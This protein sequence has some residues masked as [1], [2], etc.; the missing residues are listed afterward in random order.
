MNDALLSTSV[1]RRTVLLSALGATAT[2][3]LGACTSSSAARKPGG[4]TNPR[5]DA[6]KK[7]IDQTEASRAANGTVISTD[8][9]MK[10]ATVDLGGLTA[11]TWTFGGELPG[12]LIRAKV[13]DTLKIAVNNSLPQPTTVH[14]HG[15]ALRN[16]MDGVPGLTQDPIGPGKAFEYTFLAAHPGTY[17]FHPHVGVQQ[18]RGLYAPLII[19]DPN[20]AGAYDAE[21]IVVLDDWTDGVG[22]SP[23]A[24]LADL[25]KNGMNMDRMDHSGMPM[26]YSEANPLGADTGDV[27]Y[28]HY[29]INGKLPTAPSTFT[30]SPGQRIRIRIINA[31]A[32]TAFRVAL[33][34]HRM[35]V[36]HTD[37]FPIIPTDVDALLLGMGERYDV[38]VTTGD[39]AFALTAAPVGKQ[40]APA[41]AVMKTGAGTAAPAGEMP[42]TSGVL[43]TV[44]K[45]QAHESVELKKTKMSKKLPATLGGDMMTY[46]WTINGVAHVRDKGIMSITQGDTGR[47]RIKNATMMFHPMHLHGHTFQVRSVNGVPMQHGPRKDTV[48]VRPME[49]VDVDFV[50][51]NPGSWM[52]HCHNAYHGEAGMMTAI[53][54]ELT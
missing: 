51:D 42:T 38:I 27:D 13:G 5:A 29:L 40:G 4:T 1:S 24:I 25:M 30:A 9:L 16:D 10:P 48:I 12:A 8:L 45:F 44:E 49:T 26:P 53:D 46:T 32:D 19:D 35:T 2:I 15:L 6:Y 52:F 34:D 31:G 37:G 23:D 3:A 28:P 21:W 43:G 17:W 33:G 20:E 18:D 36:T 41:L 22:Q 11:E 14:W 47:L 7:L 39:G 50:A 54:Y